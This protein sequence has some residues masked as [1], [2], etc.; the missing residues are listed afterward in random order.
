[1]WKFNRFAFIWI[2]LDPTSRAR[3]LSPEIAGTILYLLATQQQSILTD[4]DNSFR[5]QDGM[6]EVSFGFHRLSAVDFH[7]SLEC[8][9][10]IS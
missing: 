7:A 10:L 4:A 5:R 2:D 3:E 8:G 6:G 1:M 9:G